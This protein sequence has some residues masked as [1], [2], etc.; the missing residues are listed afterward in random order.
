MTVA[1]R[2]RFDRDDSRG[3]RDRVAAHPRTRVRRR[4]SVLTALAVV[5]GLSLQLGSTPAAVA[6]PAPVGNDFVVTTGDLSFIL[7][8][9]KIAERHTTTLTAS[10]PCGTLVNQPG[11]TIP[12]AEQVPD[13]LTS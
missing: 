3:A 9:I 5:I 6:A 1:T 7:K 11:D 13:Y 4:L 8:Q 12:D 10:S 2:G